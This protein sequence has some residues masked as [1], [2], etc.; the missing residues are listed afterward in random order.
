MEELPEPIEK[1]E[2]N[3]EENQSEMDELILAITSKE[4]SWVK[5][6]K[7]KNYL[8]LKIR[9]R[10]PLQKPLQSMEETIPMAK[11]RTKSCSTRRKSQHWKDVPQS[12]ETSSGEKKT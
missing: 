12:L 8:G 6:K 5:T 1:I 2:D 4:R 3:F 9:E 10:K 11:T 7:I